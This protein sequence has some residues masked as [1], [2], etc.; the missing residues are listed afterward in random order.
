MLIPASVAPEAVVA[1]DPHVAHKI[2][3]LVAREETE[4]PL[5]R[6]WPA[7]DR[8]DAWSRSVPGDLA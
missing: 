2:G 8:R 7:I 1:I 5:E 3:K 4:S 6:R